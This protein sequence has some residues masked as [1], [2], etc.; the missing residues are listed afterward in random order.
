MRGVG[1]RR[2][3]GV[4][5]L[6]ICIGGAL[7]G[8]PRRLA[9]QHVPELEDVGL[10]RRVPLQHVFPG[11]HEGCFKAVGDD[12]AHAMTGHHEPLEGQLLDRLAQGRA[13]YAKFGRELALGRQAVARFERPFQNACFEV[14]RDGVGDVLRCGSESGHLCF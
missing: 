7:R 4:Q 1:E 3:C 14:D 8:Q 10:K 9:F 6:Q 12:R 2:V 13:R 11:I 5:A